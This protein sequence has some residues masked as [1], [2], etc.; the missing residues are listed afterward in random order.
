MVKIVSNHTTGGI[1]SV[2]RL[3]QSA[4]NAGVKTLI[5][6]DNN[7][8]GIFQFK[9]ACETYQ[10]N[11]I[12]WFTLPIAWSFLPESL[13]VAKNDEGLSELVEI[14]NTFDVWKDYFDE[15]YFSKFKNIYFIINTLDLKDKIWTFER[16][17]W[18]KIKG[19]LSSFFYYFSNQIILNEN[20][21]E[22]LK[23]EAFTELTTYKIIKNL[24]TIK[25]FKS[26][27]SEKEFKDKLTSFIFQKEG[28]IVPDFATLE[29]EVSILRLNKEYN[30]IPLSA[31]EEN[32]NEILFKSSFESYTFESLKNFYNHNSLENPYLDIDISDSEQLE[33][34]TS[35]LLTNFIN[36][37]KF[38]DKSSYDEI[39]N[40]LNK[41]LTYIRESNLSG[42]ILSLYSLSLEFKRK[43]IKIKTRGFCQSS[44]VL[45]LFWLTSIN[46]IDNK[47]Y[48]DIFIKNIFKERKGFDFEIPLNLSTV[49]KL[50]LL[51]NVYGDNF[52][53]MWIHLHN[54]SNKL[55]KDLII[56]FENNFWNDLSTNEKKILER[57]KKGV[58][59]VEDGELY[60]SKDT[61]E[62]LYH[63]R[64]YL[65]FYELI[66]KARGERKSN[67]STSS[68]FYK[69]FIGTDIRK[70]IPSWSYPRKFTDVVISDV[71]DLEGEFKP[72]EINILKTKELSN[73]KDSWDIDFSEPK[74]FELIKEKITNLN[75]ES[76]KQITLLNSHL[77]IKKE[78]WI[79]IIK[80]NVKTFKDLTNI[81]LLKHIIDI[82]WINKTLNLFDKDFNLI[83]G[84][85]K[86][87]NRIYNEI[88][89][90]S[91]YQI[92]YI[93]Q[94]YEILNKCF[95]LNYEEIKE[96]LDFV[97][98]VGKSS[99][100]ITVNKYEEDCL[101][102]KILLKKE[103]KM[104][105]TNENYFLIDKIS[106]SLSYV[107][108]RW[109]C[110]GMAENICYQL[111]SQE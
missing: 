19:W 111:G 23:E 72:L 87:S 98:E 58:K 81:F 64:G 78:D 107:F 33:F 8:R 63:N 16:Y 38:K 14:Y 88:T 54:N 99:K 51:K 30:Y 20:D 27:Y 97:K 57:L 4:K 69:F 40:I 66:F 106:N 68:L 89:K 110:Y 47:I 56:F 96:I 94:V 10:V 21:S 65:D 34:I 31:E 15:E 55:K 50:K 24:S 35:K 37:N 3:V 108:N 91:Y 101:R 86:T 77:D 60:S 46:P 9:K 93:N 18:N 59:V 52:I 6:S 85:N 26:E 70:Q 48:D 67:Q 103:L 11:P 105:I 80:N 49:D 17:K 1:E 41:E 74:Q 82:K 102:N 36:S 95:W 32:S 2:D 71:L 5:L 13:I 7:L 53:A 44:L 75:E 12:I 29:K 61:L 92:F 84:E 62:N 42:F 90:D 104:K 28:E 79:K 76:L 83:L 25:L 22:N 43:D 45:Y 39:K 73:L 100:E 109:F